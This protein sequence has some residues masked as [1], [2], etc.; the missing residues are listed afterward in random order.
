MCFVYHAHT[1]DRITE[2]FIFSE[3]KY[4]IKAIVL[5]HLKL[6]LIIIKRHMHMDSS[7]IAKK[8]FLKIVVAV[9]VLLTR[10]NYGFE[11]SDTNTST[12][13]WKSMVCIGAT[14]SVGI[15]AAYLFGRLVGRSES[16]IESERNRQQL[17]RSHTSLEQQNSALT[18]RNIEL[19]QENQ[20]LRDA[21]AQEQQ[22]RFNLEVR[23]GPVSAPPPPLPADE[24]PWWKRLFSSSSMPKP[25][26]YKDSGLQ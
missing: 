21:L 7:S 15:S 26:S 14:L 17:Q 25:P 3:G 23:Y 11:E 12:S 22:E 19:M 18:Q 10:S 8:Y 4:K 2:S 5:L 16:F 9:L 6:D 24:N 20:Q 13:S 1:F